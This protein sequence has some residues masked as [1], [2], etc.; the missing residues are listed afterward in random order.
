MYHHSP[1]VSLPAPVKSGGFDAIR[2]NMAMAMIGQTVDLMAD[3]H[4]IIHGIVAGVITEAGIPKLVVGRRVYDLSQMLT[5]T[6]TP[7]N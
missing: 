1:A 4:R 3:A 6:P 5:A 2:V 7:L